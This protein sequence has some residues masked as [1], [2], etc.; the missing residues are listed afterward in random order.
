[1]TRRRPS[2][3]WPGGSPPGWR[4]IRAAV[5][6]RDRHRC[7]IQGPTCTAIA[8]QVHHLGS[9]HTTGDNPKHLVSACAA[10]NAAIGDPTRGDPAPRPT[11]WWNTP[12]QSP[13]IESPGSPYP[14]HQ[15]NPENPSGAK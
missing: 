4:R 12:T 1:M 13:Q 5:L 11:H 7:R 6:D 2:R 15:G 9:R 3:H 8:T 14:P 10:C